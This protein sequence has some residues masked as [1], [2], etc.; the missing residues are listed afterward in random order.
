MELTLTG[1]HH[2]TAVT[3]RASDNFAF[4]TQTLGMR[5]VKKTVNQDD[6]RAYHLFYGDGV[7][8]PGS[9]ITFFDWPDVPPEQRGSHTITRTGLRVRHA[10]SL[11]WWAT[12]FAEAGVTHSAIVER[13]GRAVLD[14][15]DFEGQ[16]LTLVEDRGL[17]D[18]EPWA[19]S[20]IP[21]EHQ[22]RGLGCITMT[23]TQLAP[24]DIVLTR[25]LGMTLLRTYPDPA[26]PRFTVH[27]FGMEGAGPAAEVHVAVR[28]DM[29]V[30]R[31]GAGGVHHVAFRVP[32]EAQHKAWE[33]RL[34]SLGIQ[35]SGIVD[36]YYFRSIYFREPNGILFELATDGPGFDVDEPLATLGERLALPPFLE[37][38]RADIE[39]NLKPLAP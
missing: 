26:A 28:P 20:P 6:V 5:L 15:E 22:I 2:L 4:Y 39:A 9:D 7:A 37:P 8:S 14:F 18:G 36:R 23:V 31:P 32:N 3:A 17:G 34:R 38:R 13:D 11:A 29:P 21:A 16:R 35:T 12:H 1:I 30:A 27:V 24:T 33:V 25:V 10:A 19:E